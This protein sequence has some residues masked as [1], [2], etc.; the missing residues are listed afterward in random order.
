MEPVVADAVPASGQTVPVAQ[1]A[2]G[3][4]VIEPQYN[5]QPPAQPQYTPPAQAFSGGGQP[6]AKFFDGITLP[7]VIIGT[8]VVGSLI[9]IAWYYKEK[10]KHRKVEYPELKT[11]V[12]DLKKKVDDLQPQEEEVRQ[13]DVFA[14]PY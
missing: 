12:E 1:P 4:P 7:D 3:Q 9:L 2:A 14:S 5:M 10:I 13:S 6:K 8:L 11:T